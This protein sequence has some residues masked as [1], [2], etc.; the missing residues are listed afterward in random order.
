MLKLF[1]LFCLVNYSYSK[2]DE[3]F[4]KNLSNVKALVLQENTVNIYSGGLLLDNF[5][6][7]QINNLFYNNEIV[8][9]KTNLKIV[10][11]KHFY[12]YMICEKDLILFS[13]KINNYQECKLIFYSFDNIQEIIVKDTL[14]I[15]KN[16]IYK[17]TLY[18][19]LRFFGLFLAV[20]FVFKIIQEDNIDFTNNIYTR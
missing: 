1:I 7:C 11:K 8:N 17:E 16:F 13:L 10:C 6:T 19:C 14:N 5:N 4:D 2:S 3:F 9:N 20:K 18:N 15:F 12:E